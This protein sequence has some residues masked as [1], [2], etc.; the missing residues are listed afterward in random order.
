[1]KLKYDELL[2][3]FAFK[4]NLRHYEVEWLRHMEPGFAAGLVAFYA[5]QLIGVQ[6]G[7]VWCE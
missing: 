1:M 6:A 4:F 2:L 5:L 3:N 7:V